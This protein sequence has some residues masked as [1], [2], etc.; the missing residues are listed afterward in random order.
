MRQ[1]LLMLLLF[2]SVVTSAPAQPAV[3]WQLVESVRFG[4]DRPEARITNVG[5]LA[6]TSDGTVYAVQVADGTV[7]VF[8]ASGAYRKTT[9][10]RGEGPG[11]F[12]R[13]RQAGTIGDT[14]WVSD[15]ALQRVSFFY[16]GTFLRTERVSFHARDPFFASTP[17][18]F[19]RDGSVVTLPAVNQ[20]LVTRGLVSRL[21]L[22][23]HRRD[24]T[25]TD[26]L[27]WLSLTNR[28][29]SAPVEPRGFFA[30]RQ[31]FADN[32]VLAAAVDGSGLAVVDRPAA[33]DANT[34]HFAV[35]RFGP[36]GTLIYAK[37]VAYVPIPLSRQRADEALAALVKPTPGGRPLRQD[38]VDKSFYRPRFFPPVTDAV[39]ATDGAV[40][41]RGEE[42][43]VPTVLYRVLDASG[44]LT[45]TL[46][47][48]RDLTIRHATTTQVYAFG[49]EDDEP[50][51]ARLRIVK[52]GR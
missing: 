17:D 24:G 21:P 14:L 48:P 47:I 7:L 5:P 35:T 33:T 37:S 3:T 6:V 20:Q 32:P 16:R 51:L 25:V 10:R 34:A 12:V 52:G 1:L 19:L 46:T 30:Y 26:T 9:G 42:T 27:R 49:I 50:Y 31:P 4:S 11:E 43:G 38:E 40:W 18:T 39:V 28:S 36:K 8:D 41:L 44:T 29:G 2:L 45:A 22:L 13:P 23:R 15:M